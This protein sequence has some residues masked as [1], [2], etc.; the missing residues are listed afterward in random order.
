MPNRPTRSMRPRMR[1]EADENTSR[2]LKEVMPRPRMRPEDKA[3]EFLGGQAI[4]RGNRASEREAK[5]FAKGGKVNGFPDLNKD[6]KVT[7][8]DV[9]K[10]RGAEGFAAGGMV[11]GCSD[12][13]MSG[14]GFRG[15]Y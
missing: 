3:E 13:Q 8:A 2:A 6:G 14:K 1:P 5:M 11:R 15:E 12:S 4:E 7:R 10:G 9:L